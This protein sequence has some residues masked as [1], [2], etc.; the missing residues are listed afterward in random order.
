MFKMLN[1]K[2]VKKLLPVVSSLV[3][4]AQCDGWNRDLVKTITDEMD[5]LTSI[6]QLVITG[7]PY[8]NVFMADSTPPSVF[9]DPDWAENGW[10]NRYRLEVSGVNGMGK[11]QPLAPG[12]YTVERLS[13]GADSVEQFRKITVT[14]N[15]SRNVP[16]PSATFEVYVTV[17]GDDYYTI[18]V[19]PNIANGSIAPFPSSARAGTPVTVY[20]NPATGWALEEGTLEITPP[21]PPARL[22]G[23]SVTPAASCNLICRTGTPS[24]PPSLFS[25]RRRW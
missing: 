12:Q 5:R 13:T 23:L 24:L 2:T 1:M 4:F 17:L 18:G 6:D 14:L 10:E 19:N 8:P 25:R 9:G 20:V 15:G 22:G 11:L 21:P 3:F 16:P 7:Y